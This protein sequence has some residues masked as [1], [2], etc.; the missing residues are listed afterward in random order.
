[1]F[2]LEVFVHGSLASGKKLGVMDV[3]LII[4]EFSCVSPV[5]MI[6]KELEN[7]VGLHFLR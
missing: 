4:D 6:A 7:L 5:T 2:H 1:M 3:F